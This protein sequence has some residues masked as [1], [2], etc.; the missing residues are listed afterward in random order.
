MSFYPNS[1]KK[2]VLITLIVLSGLTG[3]MAVVVFQ[4]NRGNSPT[5]T[6]NQSITPT[7]QVGLIRTPTPFFTLPQPTTNPPIRLPETGIS[8][9]RIVSTATITQPQPATATLSLT[10][11]GTSTS[12][13]PKAAL[14]TALHTATNSIPQP[15]NVDP[16]QPCTDKAAFF[17]DVTIPDNTPFFQNVPF[18]K[19]WRIRNE[20]TCTWGAGYTLVFFGGNAMDGAFSNPVPEIAPGEVGDISVNLRSPAS[21][22]TFTGYW[23]FQNPAGKRFGVNSNGVD[24]IWVKIGVRGFDEQKTPAPVVGGVSASTPP[25]G[26]AAQENK[27]YEEEILEQI[28]QERQKAGLQALRVSPLLSKAAFLH[29]QDMGCNRFVD[30]VGSNGSTWYNRINSQGYS[31]STATENIYVGDPQ[32]GGNPAGAMKW[33]MNSKIHR[34]NI[35]SARVTEIGIGYAYIPTSPYK[36]YYTLKFARP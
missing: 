32:M 13:V 36:G 17:G 28:N 30:H 5:Q 6:R 29:S 12:F 33:W 26:C 20:G 4:S 1:P 34:E 3:M 21:A 2:L 27:G 11:T 22:G 8:P 10:L 9:T 31:Y 19:T 24:T 35:L 23:V 14:P 18:V 25:A 7:E 15:L 16:V